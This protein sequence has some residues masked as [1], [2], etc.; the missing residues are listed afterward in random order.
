MK[1]KTA[2]S[3]EYIFNVITGILYLPFKLVSVIIY[4]ILQPFVWLENKRGDLTWYVGNRLLK[5]SDEVKTNYIKNKEMIM[6]YTA[7]TVNHLWEK[8]NRFNKN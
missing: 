1:L 8:E 4:F 3:I 7:R 2:A 5:R 6:R